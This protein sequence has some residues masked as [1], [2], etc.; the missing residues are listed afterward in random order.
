MKYFN[1]KMEWIKEVCDLGVERV[2]WKFYLWISYK[3]LVLS[4]N[5]WLD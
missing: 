5:L 1:G 4:T 3:K 2:S